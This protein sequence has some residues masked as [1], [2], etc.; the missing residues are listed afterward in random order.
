MSL[1]PAHDVIIRS[2]RWT[3]TPSGDTPAMTDANGAILCLCTGNTC[4]SP[5]LATLVR[6]ALRNAGRTDVTVVSAGT[7]A[8]SGMPASDGAQRAM[9]RRGLVLD[10]HRSQS[11][12]DID[13][14]A[15]RR[16]YAMSAHH[17]A[18]A[19]SQGVPAERIV[20]VNEAQGGV[21]D[22]WGGDDE[23]Y[24]ACA[25]VLELAARD[26]VLEVP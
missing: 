25:Q 12:A 1:W 9:N 13:P 2:H 18:A 24:E 6:A 16:V 22:P 11:L 4:R 7:G 20:I 3:T 5:M 17:A 10:Q 23:H 19:R 21:P 15:V 8:I 14:A 26:I